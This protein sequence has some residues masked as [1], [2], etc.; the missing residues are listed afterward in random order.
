MT[1]WS[2]H[3]YLQSP[4][5][6]AP[7]PCDTRPTP[8]LWACWR[9]WDPA[10]W[11]WPWAGTPSQWWPS[12][13]SPAPPAGHIEAEQRVEAQSDGCNIFK[14]VFLTAGESFKVTGRYK[15]LSQNAIKKKRS[16]KCIFWKSAFHA[17]LLYT[18][19]LLQRQAMRWGEKEATEHQQACRCYQ[20]K[21]L[22]CIKQ[23]NSIYTLK[24][25][26]AF[27]KF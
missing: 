14:A 12:M 18:K 23:Y 4:S 19:L 21:N 9:G 24:S 22:G 8:G 15:L 6:S 1:F 3:N 13:R 10:C 11:Q 26:K 27:V 25:L 2:R 7:P 5:A 16:P 20:V 17:L